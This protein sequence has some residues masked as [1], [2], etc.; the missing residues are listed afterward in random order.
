[1]TVSPP[2]VS[3]PLSAERVLESPP[4]FPPWA[5]NAIWISSAA[6]LSLN[7]IA[8]ALLDRLARSSPHLE[9]AVTLFTF[10][11]AM[12][13][14]SR[15]RAARLPETALV[16]AVYTPTAVARVAEFLGFGAPIGVPPT[17]ITRVFAG[18]MLL[19]GTFLIAA[20]DPARRERGVRASLFGS[21]ATWSV[22]V[23]AGIAAVALELLPAGRFALL[24]EVL[25]GACCAALMLGISHRL[26]RR[27]PGPISDALRISIVPF[28]A[29]AAIRVLPSPLAPDE[30]HFL[31]LGFTF[32]GHIVNIIGLLLDAL[33][34]SRERLAAAS[35]LAEANRKLASSTA[36]I[37]ELD[38]RLSETTEEV[39]RFSSRARMLESAV[40]TMSLGV[41]VTDLDGAIVYVN[42]ADAAL[43]G[44]RQ[45][46]LLGRPATLFED[47]AAP[48]PIPPATTRAQPWARETTNVTRD[49]ERIPVRLVSDLVRGAAGEPVGRVTVCEDIRRERRI[50]HAL[51]SRIR[52]LTACGVIAEHLFANDTSRDSLPFALRLLAEATDSD[53]AHFECD[54]ALPLHRHSHW[55]AAPPESQPPAFP[56]I[57][58]GAPVVEPAP[59]PASGS[60]DMLPAEVAFPLRERGMRS[61]ALIRVPIESD[62]ACA[63]LLAARDP[64]RAWNDGELEAATIAARSLAAAVRRDRARERLDAEAILFQRLVDEA[65]D[66]IQSLAPDGTILYVNEAWGRTLGCD[67]E[68]AVGRSIYDFVAEESRQACERERHELESDGGSRR[69]E[70]VLLTVGGDRIEVEG[71]ISAHRRADGTPSTLGIL[72]DITERRRLER[73]QQEFLSTVS[74]ELRTP[75]TSLLGSLMLLRNERVAASREQS[76]ELLDIAERNGDRLLRLINDLLDLRRLEASGLRVQIADVPVG[77]V[78]QA[79]EEG[80]RGFADSYGVKV[81]TF[82]LTGGAGIHTDRERLVQ[83][84]FNLLSNGIKFS[85]PHGVVELTAREDRDRIAL[86]VVDQ[87]PGFP[88]E[89][90]P[91]LFQPFVEPEERS[92]R[93][94]GASG[95]GLAIAKGIVTALSGEIRIDAAPSGGTRVSVLLPRARPRV[96]VPAPS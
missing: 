24:A 63:L 29:A 35:R 33:R 62:A 23:A 17:S 47:P 32:L 45:T 94:G 65:S 89:L 21:A 91:R 2:P 14:W 39:L 64:D 73:L 30:R 68:L 51:S 79:T 61:V 81:V 66:L 31:V 52:I 1:V 25:F 40:E 54:A 42:R 9:L 76:T 77:E 72:R 37:H 59:A 53:L 19:L 69:F 46:E 26:C 88:D 41:T 3:G 44:Y 38:H 15:L 87:G 16:A 11:V 71:A 28:A 55:R 84:L 13:S 67:P 22:L 43:H 8:P 20:P 5:S 49:G 70:A 6:L 36:A 78:L 34:D 27:Y 83:V 57:L 50:E 90:K 7:W 86:D 74:H 80:I 58:A 82:D 12:L 75:L 85:P 56:Q 93:K 96:A 92:R 4:R 10:A 48:R 60:V 18:L 95:L